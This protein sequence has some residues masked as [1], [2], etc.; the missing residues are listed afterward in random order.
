MTP[1]EPDF[2]ENA[3]AL[4]QAGQPDEALA[5]L[6]QAIGRM[7]TGWTP[8]QQQG[9]DEIVYCWDH[10]EFI[11]YCH[12]RQSASPQAASIRYEAGSYSQACWLAGSLYIDR[13]DFPEALRFLNLG[14]ELEPTHPELICEKAYVH[15]TQKQYQQALELFRQAEQG[16]LWI[17]DAQKARA[18][19]GQGICLVDLGRLDEAA[20]VLLRAQQVDP[21]DTRA[22][23]E[24]EFIRG[25]R[26][27]SSQSG[28]LG[29]PFLQI[30][31]PP[32]DPLTRRLVELVK[33]SPSIPGPQTVGSANFRLI[34]QAFRERGWD[35]FEEEFAKLYKRDHPQHEEMKA[36]LL[37]EPC[38]RPQTYENMAKLLRAYQA[39][40]EKRLRKAY[41]E[42]GREETPGKPS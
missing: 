3:L 25:L 23:R 15:Q 29:W 26:L 22:A 6:A 18:L 1:G 34:Q 11:E 33:D 21:Q 36:R 13:R 41:S 30:L 35:G 12:Y 24:L 40:G 7:P 39:G 14:L 8:I 5:V 38:F 10:D 42:I 28:E 31:N 19:R 2:T 20:N 4:I 16:R 32:K 17:T 27:E 9:K 37:Q